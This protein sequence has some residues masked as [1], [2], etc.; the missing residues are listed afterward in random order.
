MGSPVMLCFPEPARRRS[1]RCVEA[2]SSYRL[3]PGV[4]AP[5]LRYAQ[6]RC[7]HLYTYLDHAE[8]GFMSLRIQTWFPYRIQIALNGREWLSRQLAREGLAFE[9]RGNK[10]LRV[11][12][13]EAAQ[14]LLDAQV[15]T[16]WCSLLDRFVPMAFPTIHST[17]SERFGYTWTLWQ[18]EWAS[19]VLFH[20]RTALD[21]VLDNAI[22]H[23]FIGAYPG[24]LL[25]YFQRPVTR[26][27]RPRRDFRDRLE[28][29]I[30]DLDEGC[31]IRHWL[32]RNSV[33]LYNEENVL[34]LETTINDPRKFRGY[35]HK[36]GESE[37][38][39][40]Q[41][42]PLRKGVADITLRSQASQEVNDRFS[43]HLATL[44]SRDSL[45]TVV[46]PPDPRR[47]RIDQR[48]S[49]GIS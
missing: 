47:P 17:L 6:T 10:I 33:K 13:I 7:K 34:R 22:R 41:L 38:N 12:D 23:A 25:R 32:G 14:R 2:G 36:Q 37:D 45:E 3:V 24:R 26:Q 11:E 29:R 44:Q 40:K 16:D 43:D 39:P 46:L 18:S 19:D 8:L 35:R 27:D 31:R 28:T 42:L 30:L 5:R 15:R 49:G 4:G 9:R 1:H 21:D 48:N 20:D